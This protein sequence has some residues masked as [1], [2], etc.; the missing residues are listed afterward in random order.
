MPQL[1]F[2]Q[3][4]ARLFDI[5]PDRGRIVRESVDAHFHARSGGLTRWLWGQRPLDDEVAAPR[6]LVW[7]GLGICLRWPCRASE[8]ESHAARADNGITSIDS[9]VFADVAHA[10]S[11]FSPN[12]HSP[13][14]IPSQQGEAGG[15]SR[16]Y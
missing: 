14:A 9:Y 13:H 15:G 11:V 2:V 6:P 3:R 10:H 16:M 12:G 8:T 1:N 4:H 5:I 7:K